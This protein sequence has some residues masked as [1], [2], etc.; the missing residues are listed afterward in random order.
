MVVRGRSSLAQSKA[1]P[2]PQEGHLA[3]VQMR[4]L[5]KALT[6]STVI[7]DGSGKIVTLSLRHAECWGLVNRHS[8]HQAQLTYSVYSQSVTVP[9][10]LGFADGTLRS[11]ASSLH[12]VLCNAS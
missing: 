8:C 12:P 10:Y 7:I 4:A 11:L 1:L 6:K 9:A 3:E 2:T 5:K